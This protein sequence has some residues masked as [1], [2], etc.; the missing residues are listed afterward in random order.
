MFLLS[1]QGFYIRIGI[2]KKRIVAALNHGFAQITRISRMLL[3][4]FATGFSYFQ[5]IRE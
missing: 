1:L 4:A 2:H 3:D 5:G